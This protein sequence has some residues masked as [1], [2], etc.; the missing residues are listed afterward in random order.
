MEQKNRKLVLIGKKTTFAEEEQ[1]IFEWERLP[2]EDKWNSLE[3][4]RIFYYRMHD[5]PFPIKIER[6]IQKM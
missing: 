4:L 6:V 3:R 1:D 2:F 5:I